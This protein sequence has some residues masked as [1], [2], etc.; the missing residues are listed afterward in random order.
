[1]CKKMPVIPVDR[2]VDKKRIIGKMKGQGGGDAQRVADPK[3]NNIGPFPHQFVRTVD[4]DGPR[5]DHVQEA[6]Q[7]LH[8]E[9]RND[10]GQLGV[11]LESIL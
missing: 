7:R 4:V 1:M 10:D 8:A 3:N 5:V 11:Q 9:V 6:G 2:V